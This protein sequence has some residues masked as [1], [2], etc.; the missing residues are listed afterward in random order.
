MS[1]MFN[2]KQFSSIYTGSYSSDSS[3]VSTSLAYA[4][5]VCTS[6]TSANYIS[7][8]VVCNYNLNWLV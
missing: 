4:L 8:I 7:A 3:I 5:M 6:L 2:S 1:Q